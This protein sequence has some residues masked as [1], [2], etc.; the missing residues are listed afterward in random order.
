MFAVKK[1]IILDEAVNGERHNT[2]DLRRESSFKN[3][4]Q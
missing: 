3:I 4:G 1:K 2:G